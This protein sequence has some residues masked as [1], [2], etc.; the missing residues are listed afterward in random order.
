MS[1]A[2]A[3]GRCYPLV[4][5]SRVRRAAENLAQAFPDMEEADRWEI[6][7]RSYEHLFQ[8]GVEILFAPRLIT[9]EGFTRH[10]VLSR[11][12]PVLYELLK[13]GPTIMV[14]AHC[15]NWELIG[16]AISLIGFPMHAVYRPLDLRPLNEWL[17][18]TRARRGLTL[19]SKFGAVR[20]LPPILTRGEPVGI[21][22][23]QSG[24]DRGL[25]VPFFG[26]L[27][28][29]YKSIGLLA[30]RT[31]ARVLCG[32]ARRMSPTESIPDGPWRQSGGGGEQFKHDLGGVPRMRYSL[33]LVDHFGPEDWEQ[34]PD[35]LYYLTARYRLA[36]EGM[37]RRAPEQYLWMHRIWRARPAHE[38]NNKPFPKNLVEKLRALPWMTPDSL[39]AIVERSERD[40]REL[41]AL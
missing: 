27:T 4:G 12:E 36:I 38:R 40:R 39:N 26:R 17:Y 22:A 1:I 10:L 5:R 34:Q 14:T 16:Y 41:A 33:E 20:T 6:A 35:P 21:V 24:G 3:L 19:V 28:S 23:D 18:D 11:I 37:I 30:M 25:Y 13:Q 8:L 2:R 15:G 9:Q 29:T 32:F 7:V 31:G